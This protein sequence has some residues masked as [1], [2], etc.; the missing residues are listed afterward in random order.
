ML[1]HHE[2]FA[3]PSQIVYTKQTLALLQERALYQAWQM[4]R[5]PGWGDPRE[6]TRSANCSILAKRMMFASKLHHQTCC[7]DISGCILAVSQYQ[8]K[9]VQGNKICYE[10][11]L[12]LF[13][14]LKFILKITVVLASY[15][16][17][18][19]T[20]IG[21]WGLGFTGMWRHMP[22]P[23]QMLRGRHTQRPPKSRGW[24]P[25]SPCRGS[26]DALHKRRPESA[27]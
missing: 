2:L 12:W 21:I 25:L 1:M 22:G 18:N 27:E 20:S 9:L 7:Q 10:T 17:H 14:R 5:S 11:V 23:A 26:A 8:S 19:S 13:S 24:S 6:P 4:R 3:N 15:P 16:R